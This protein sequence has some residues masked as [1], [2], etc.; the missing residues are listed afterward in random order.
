MESSI[1]APRAP[2]KEDE[3]I[4][5][6]SRRDKTLAL[7]GTLVALLMA[8][9]DQTIVAT[10]GPEI[11]RDLQI[12]AVL[13]AWLTTAYLVAST[14]ML[15]IYGKLSDLFGRKPLLIVGVG[16][17]LLGSL[18]CGF[19]PTTGFLI[20]ARVVQ[21][22]GAASLFTTTLAVIADLFPPNERGKYMG[23]IGAVMGISSII[24]PI[25][26]GIITDLLGWHWVFF[27]NI[28]VGLVALWL[29]VTKMPRLGGRNGQRVRIDFM[30]AFW[31][32][33]TVVPMMLALS[34]GAGAGVDFGWTSWPI[35]AMLGGSAVSLLIFLA[36][37]RVAPEPILDLR[38]FSGN[39]T[40]AVA[41]LT[42]FTLGA[43]F[44]FTII[45][46]PLF[47]VNVVGISATRAGLSLMPL[48]LAMVATSVLAGQIASRLGTIK[49]L[50][51]GSLILLAGGFLLMQA[52]I[53]ADA[54]QGMITLTLVL[55]GLGMGPT[56]PLY[57]LLVQN[58]ANPSQIGV[59][60]SGSIFARSI[61]Q[62]FGLAL[63]GTVFAATLAGSLDSRTSN[64][65]EGLPI[66]A[67]EIVAPA[68]LTMR[69]EDRGTSMRFEGG[70]VRERIVASPVLN[71]D[72]RQRALAA[73]DQVER[74][75]ADSLSRAIAI[76]Y[77]IGT[78]FV[79]V[80]LLLTMMIPAQRA[81]KG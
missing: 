54:T 50:L 3:G 8:G 26:G 20:G 73:V 76:L 29:I 43:T 42:M 56:L 5:V 68:L 9:L 81:K 47:L 1:A 16:L 67:R 74:A 78:G 19:A 12:P 36:V 23:L 53:T 37:E 34:L 41:T 38:L 28:P 33:A 27:V 72:S 44:L 66:E 55:I 48:T 32:I 70:V 14:V 69:G 49:G 10:A 58:A 79:L 64:V 77:R 52:T 35:L 31:L 40:V 62:V 51:I 39:R 18:L 17:F 24:G 2:E 6:L 11:Q 45:F 46:L 80:A 71:I 63:F 57:M 7:A 13:Y 30:G 21:G 60:T 15:P 65:L 59:A 25:A 75:F 61:G 22:L 4:P